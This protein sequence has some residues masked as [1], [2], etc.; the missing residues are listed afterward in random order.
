MKSLILLF[1]F[2]LVVLGISFLIKGQSNSV[3]LDHVCGKQVPWYDAAFL[4]E[5]DGKASCEKFQ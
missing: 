4:E 1:L 2:A 5:V 3:N